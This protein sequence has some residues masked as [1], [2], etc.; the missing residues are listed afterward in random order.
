[1]TGMTQGS[2]SG[3]H[4][5]RPFFKGL[6][7]RG[8]AQVDLVQEPAVCYVA[9]LMTDFISTD[10]LYP[11]HDGD[12]NRMEYL[13][14]LVAEA[15]KAVEPS[16]RR[17]QFRYLGDLTLF[18]LGL[19]PERFL[20]GRHAMTREFYRIQGRSGPRGSIVLGRQCIP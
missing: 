5:I 4:P 19:F 15:H 11:V 7:R 18:M 2:V 9:D 12:G 14:D 8:L 10:Q 20:R 1:M 3:N 6:V 13:S 17:D 16:L